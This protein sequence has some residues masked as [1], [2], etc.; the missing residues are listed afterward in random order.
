MS[1]FV[2]AP[3][4]SVPALRR[5]GAAAVALLIFGVAFASVLTLAGGGRSV[6]GRATLGPGAEHEDP[7]TIPSIPAWQELHPGSAP[8]NDS[9]GMAYDAAD[10]YF[11][12]VSIDRGSNAPQTWA[13]ADGQW[14]QLHPASSLPDDCIG[15]LTYDASDGYVVTYCMT[16]AWYPQTWEFHGG[17]WTNITSESPVAP[18]PR[19]VTAMTYDTAIGKVVLFG[20]WCGGDCPTNQSDA[21]EGLFNDTWVFHAGTWTRVPTDLTPPDQDGGTMAYDPSTGSV[22][23]YGGDMEYTVEK[24]VNGSVVSGGGWNGPTN[25]TWTFNGSAW[26]NVTSA[27]PEPWEGAALCS[28]PAVGGLVAFGGTIQG[29][30]FPNRNGSWSNATWAWRNGSWVGL[31]LSPA[32]SPRA[33]SAMAYDPAD[34][35]DL[36]FGGSGPA[37]G[38]TGPGPGIPRNDTWLLN[39]SEQAST[40]FPLSFSESGLPAGTNWSVA[41]T[42]SGSGVTI[43]STATLTKWSNGGVI[44]EFRVSPGTYTYAAGALGYATISGSVEVSGA[45]GVTETV[46]FP[47][48]PGSG[49]PLSVQT[50]WVGLGFA[51]LA[52][53]GLSLTMYRGRVRERQRGRALA[54]RLAESDWQADPLGLPEIWRG[55]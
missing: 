53:A 14:A 27:G 42:A 22:F 39:T 21:S 12:E 8:P 9:F 51:A 16:D 52:A 1:A 13:F 23:L 44:V 40:L 4:G 11:I 48:S 26:T 33:G 25:S 15:P 41:L 37:N 29:S 28:D 32:P 38:M 24:V 36:L 18:A 5:V 31:S 19:E 10:G 49:P 35:Y 3:R 50:A 54:R 55:P 17:N 7:A 30:T 6:G 45:A 2:P 43:E 20:G 46:D 34:G 47:G